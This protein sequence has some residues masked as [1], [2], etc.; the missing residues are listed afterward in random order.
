MDAVDGLHGEPTFYH[1]HVKRSLPARVV[2]GHAYSLTVHLS[3]E[4]DLY[5]P[6]AAHAAC[7]PLIV[8]IACHPLLS[9]AAHPSPTVTVQPPS[10]PL[11]SKTGRGSFDI[12]LSAACQSQCTTSTFFYLHLS[13]S[14]ALSSSIL[15]AVSGPHELLPQGC[16]AAQ[17]GEEEAAEQELL[18]AVTIAGDASD[19]RY[20][21]IREVCGTFIG[22]RVWDCSLYL[23]RYVSSHILQADS[24]PEQQAVSACSAR[25]AVSDMNASLFLHKRILE[26]GS[27]T[28]VFGLWLAASLSSRLPVC[29]SRDAATTQLILTDQPEAMPL[30]CHNLQRN[31]S[32][33]GS[34]QLSVSASPLLFGDRGHL[35]SLQSQLPVELVVASDVVFNAAYFTALLQTLSAVMRTGSRALFSYRPRGGLG[36][37]D[38]APF[39]K[40]LR[41][42]GLLYEVVK[43][44]DNVYIVWMLRV[45]EAEAQSASGTV[46]QQLR[47]VDDVG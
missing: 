46:G 24:R 43:R 14:G 41:R 25:P 37:R 1:L 16:K 32:S 13:L 18:H 30:L 31:S 45:S 21:L 42:H 15:P 38:D 26:L 6:N 20:V 9:S 8:N 23:M 4:M 35:Q 28:G 11:L 39:W 22:G 7:R 34:D 33:M 10:K 19:R 5:I 36:S 40:G 47:Q 27:G 3:N 12:A 44:Y 2:P 17:R 29:S